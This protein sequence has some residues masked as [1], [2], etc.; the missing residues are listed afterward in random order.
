MRKLQIVLFLYISLISLTA[1]AQ[2]VRFDREGVE[3][4]LEL[5]SSEWKAVPR[6][7][8]HEHVEFIYGDEQKNGYL[9]LRKNMVDAG[10]TATDL[11]SR[12]EKWSLH[13]LPGYVICGECKGEKFDGNLSGMTF[14]FEYTSGGKLMAGRIYYLQV[15]NRIFY[16]LHFTAARDKLQ[17]L[18]SQMESIARSFRLK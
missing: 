1:A 5:P 15:N 17:D 2:T 12:D 7:D 14:S 3:Y 4:R 10:T 6:L 13:F 9:R 11:F 16:T 18:S 8:V